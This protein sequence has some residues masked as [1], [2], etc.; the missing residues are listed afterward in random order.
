MPFGVCPLQSVERPRRG[1]STG[2]MQPVAQTPC[3]SETDN[4]HTYGLRSIFPDAQVA[5]ENDW[6]L[7]RA[8]GRETLR[9]FFDT[10]RGN[11]AVPC[12]PSVHT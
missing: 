12:S 6:T 11:R 4:S 1:L 3:P 10:P 7:F 8:C 2:G 5:R 9:G